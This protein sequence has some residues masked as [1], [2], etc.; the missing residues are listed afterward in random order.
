[1]HACTSKGKSFWSLCRKVKHQPRIIIWKDFGGIRATRVTN[2]FIPS[3]QGS[4]FFWF[5]R[6]RFFK[7]L[8]PYMGMVASLVNR[9]EPFEHTFFPPVSGCLLWNL[10]LIGQLASEEKMFENVDGWWMPDY[11]ISLPQDFGS[12]KVQKLGD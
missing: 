8:L 1:M 4:K 2:A 3:F 5:W 11:T 7:G 6:R 9:L 12:K 10:V